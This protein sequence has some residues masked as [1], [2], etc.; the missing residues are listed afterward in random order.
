MDRARG[1]RRSEKPSKRENSPDPRG[2]E[3]RR[4]VEGPRLRT[5]GT[6]TSGLRDKFSETE[7]K[8]S[9]SPP[10]NAE[11]KPKRRSPLAARDA[12][13][14][15]L[16]KAEKPPAP[17]KDDAEQRRPTP[18]A[19]EAP[20]KI[21]A[22]E[23]KIT[24]RES[25]STPLASKPKRPRSSAPSPQVIYADIIWDDAAGSGNATATGG[26]DASDA[27][28]PLL[29]HREKSRDLR[30][31]S[32]TRLEE[33]QAKKELQARDEEGIEGHRG[34][35]VSSPSDS[36][37]ERGREGRKARSRSPKRD[38]EPNPQA[39]HT[40]GEDTRGQKQP[41]E[42]PE[43]KKAK[44]KAEKEKFEAKLK[45]RKRQTALEIHEDILKDTKLLYFL[46]TRKEKE[47]EASDA[48]P[49]DEYWDLQRRREEI[50]KRFNDNAFALQ[51]F[52]EA[53][54]LK[55]DQKIHG[56]VKAENKVDEEVLGWI[57][58][59]KKL[60]D[61]LQ[62]NAVLL[63]RVHIHDGLNARKMAGMRA[64]K[65]KKVIEK[66]AKT[67]E[68]DMERSHRIDVM[69]DVNE[70]DCEL[71]EQWIKNKTPITLREEKGLKLLARKS[72]KVEDLS[73][74]DL[75]L[76]WRNDALKKLDQ[77]DKQKKQ[78]HEKALI[79]CTVT[80]FDKLEDFRNS[81]KAATK[82]IEGEEDDVL[83]LGELGKVRFA[84]FLPAISST[85]MLTS[86]FTQDVISE[87]KLRVFLWAGDYR[88][89]YRHHVNEDKELVDIKE[90]LPD[91]EQ[92]EDMLRYE[93]EQ[94]KPA[95]PDKYRSIKFVKVKE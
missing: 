44:K 53:E 79:L 2:A 57:N 92:I 50:E 68:A 13:D 51:D 36:P 4:T 18:R 91:P 48:P 10:S 15:Q 38:Q 84:G 76:G 56:K 17:R 40:E 42:D 52:L 32:R 54:V 61:H 88:R 20:K 65:L 26:K 30:S 78:R 67:T 73:M 58:E 89:R 14:A 66:V 25:T 39:V 11:P 94:S 95:K 28:R 1:L 82:V 80:A 75:A 19:R 33:E 31:L 83:F 62:E 37:D 47:L 86:A 27:R 41:V 81:L 3:A 60:D 16:P 77:T 63:R 29:L 64:D 34:R 85:I 22:A 70:S 43:K 45:A 21:P 7:K 59:K 5:S 55:L 24:A 93:E 23:D 87:L 6:S 46:V 8:P 12:N 35:G 71:V 69:K 72:G 90:L 74:E 9:P 49:D